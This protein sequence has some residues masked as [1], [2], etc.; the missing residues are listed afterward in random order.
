M[1]TQGFVGQRGRL[2]I[3]VVYLAGLFVASWIALGTWLPP[4]SQRGL[5]FYSALAALLLGSLLVTPFFTKPVDAISYAVASIIGLLSVNPWSDPDTLGFERF[6]WSI[7]VGYGLLV[8][9]PA[10]VAISLKDSSR[11]ST[12]NIAR[13]GLLLVSIPR[14]K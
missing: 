10:V 12:Q 8:L 9:V 6:A 1:T 5:W 3:L 4:T 13:S 14:E 11:R 2:I 7:T